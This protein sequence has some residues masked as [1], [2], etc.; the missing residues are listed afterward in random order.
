MEILKKEYLEKT[1]KTWDDI[2]DLKTPCQ[3][4]AFKN[5][6]FDFI[7]YTTPSLQK[8]LEKLKK[9]SIDPNNKD[10]REVFEI[11]DVVHNI[12]LGGLHSINNAEIIIPPSAEK[13]Q[14]CSKY[15]FRK[16][17]RTTRL[18]IIIHH[19]RALFVLNTCS[20]IYSS[21]ILCSSRFTNALINSSGFTGT[22]D[23]KFFFS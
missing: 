10:F 18:T 15:T 3:L 11:G 2:K 5:V 8:L 1:N 19:L 13:A 12:S 6:I 16:I 7:Q 22:N 4:V 14:L 23:N 9:I 20:I 21:S 17:I